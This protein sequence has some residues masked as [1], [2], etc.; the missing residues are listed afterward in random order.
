MLFNNGVFLPS[1]VYMN[2]TFCNVLKCFCFGEG[3]WA[4]GSGVTKA[5]DGGGC[6]LN[7]LPKSGGDPTPICPLCSRAA[8]EWRSPA[9]PAGTWSDGRPAHSPKPSGGNYDKVLFKRGAD[10]PAAPRPPPHPVIY[11]IIPF[12]DTLNPPTS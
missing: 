3:G 5:G 2:T 7:T 4:Y 10:G 6:L 1:N 8:C 11:N 12:N 9:G